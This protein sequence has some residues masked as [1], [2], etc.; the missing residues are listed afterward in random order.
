MPCY[1]EKHNNVAR[2]SIV[3][4]RRTQRDVYNF[5][6]SE[7]A[8][9]ASILYH[10]SESFKTPAEPQSYVCR[11]TVA[12]REGAQSTSKTLQFTSVLEIC[13]KKYMACSF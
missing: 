11:V 5:A 1:T 6:L 8:L 7:V 4:F 12:M 3:I 2:E 13:T 10:R 9:Q